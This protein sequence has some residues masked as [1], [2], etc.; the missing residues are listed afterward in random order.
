VSVLGLCELTTQLNSIL[1]WGFEMG[2]VEK[3]DGLIERITALRDN[4]A[5]PAPSATK[6]KMAVTPSISKAM[7][8]RV[9]RAAISDSTCIRM[10][11]GR[12]GMTKGSLA[13]SFKWTGG[14]GG[15][16]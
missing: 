9:P 4:M 5:Q 15:S 3:A 12:L 13:T 6:S 10:A 16:S 8:G 11:L 7:R 1:S 14:G 2:R